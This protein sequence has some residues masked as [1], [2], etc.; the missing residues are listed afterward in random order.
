MLCSDKTVKLPHSPTTTIQHPSP[1]MIEQRQT[2][3]DER[4]QEVQREQVCVVQGPAQLR[5]VVYQQRERDHHGLARL[6]TV[7]ARQDVDGVSAEHRQQAH[8]HV[9][10]WT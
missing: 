2:D 7:H 3:A 10:Q 8:V 9:V 6:Q 1:V 5:Q 4:Q